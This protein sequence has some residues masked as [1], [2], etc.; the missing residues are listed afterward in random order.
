MVVELLHAGDPTVAGSTPGTSDNLAQ[1]NLLIVQTANPGSE[2]TRTVQHAFNIDLTRSLRRPRRDPV[3]IVDP[4]HHHHPPADASHERPHHGGHAAPHAGHGDD[5]D[6][7][8][9]HD[10][11]DDHDHDDHDHDHDRRS[12]AAQLLRRDQR[13]SARPVGAAQAACHHDLHIANSPTGA[14]AGLAQ[15]P[16]LLKKFKPT[17]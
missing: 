14:K 2:I 10:H 13:S 17:G 5:H 6:H 1:R 7:G 4:I 16:G 15:S 11:G 8:G 9:D 3:P 12:C